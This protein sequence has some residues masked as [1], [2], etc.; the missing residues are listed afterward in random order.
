MKLP[1]RPRTVLF[2][3]A[4]TGAGHRS[5]ANAIHRAMQ[6]LNTTTPAK[7]GG[8]SARQGQWK[9][10]IVDVFAECSRF[11]LRNGIF[12]YGPA[13]KHSPRL[14]GQIFRMT[15]SRSRFDRAW[16]LCQPF[17]REGIRGLLERTQ[18]DVIVSIHPL[19]NHVTLQVLR[20]MR[21]RVPFVTVVTDLVN[22]HC[23]WIAPRVDACIVPTKEARQVALEAGVPA[24]RI[25]LLG[26]PIDPSFA[27]PN[28]VPL[29]ERRRAL[30]LDPH[31]PVIL[32][33]GGG[34][35]AGG[36]AEAAE[37]LSR[38]R[39]PAQLVIVA[40]RNRQLYQELESIRD[41]FHM[42][43]K[44]FGFVNTMPDLMRAADVIVTKAGP[45][46]ICEAVACGLPILLTGAVPGQEEGNVDY[47]L[48]HELGE[49]VT[50]P[51]ALVSA[52]TRLLNPDN[53][54]LDAMRERAKQYNHA[55]ASLEIAR[56]VIS[57]LPSPESPSAWANRM[58]SVRPRPT[59]ALARPPRILLPRLASLTA[60]GRAPQHVGVAVRR[61]AQRRR[62]S[63]Y[64]AFGRA[65]LA[66]VQAVLRRA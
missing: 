53:T 8:S 13:I 31:L 46:T 23:A 26:M 65:N 39:L 5:A 36:L 9:A 20:D 56:Y 28:P 42:P 34:E 11:P 3:I 60:P 30:G 48:E 57:L 22:V 37:T 14:Y 2:L 40:G 35:G 63:H 19:L 16:R 47:V 44:L 18:P 32:L 55:A 17:V 43:V 51:A 1:R 61:G 7:G 24:K 12:L 50:T 41:S 49:L 58:R 25:R 64:A 52:L 15:N 27:R 10:V 6:A 38:Q 33:V 29:E 66:K 54:D 45:G 21:V 4:D 62:I 59:L